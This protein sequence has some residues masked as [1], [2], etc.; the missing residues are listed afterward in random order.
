MLKKE[1]K[2]M[3]K[4]ISAIVMTG[5]ILFALPEGNEVQ[6]ASAKTVKVTSQKY[7]SVQGNL[8][9]S[10]KGLINKKTGKKFK[11]VNKNPFHYYAYKDGTTKAATYVKNGRVF[12]KKTKKPYNG[13][14]SEVNFAYA[15]SST[16]K[17]KNGYIVKLKSEK[18]E[19]IPGITKDGYGK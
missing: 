7:F 18:L 19:K 12:S 4:I 1:G 9:Y 15:V 17:I 5:A 10:K 6:E 3:K 11:K 16:A 13:K 2:K 8:Y 14:I